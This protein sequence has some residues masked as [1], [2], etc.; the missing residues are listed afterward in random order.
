[1]AAA[2]ATIPG[3]T[4]VV[5]LVAVVPVA[6]VMEAAAQEII[7]DG[8]AVALVEAIMEIITEVAQAMV[9]QIPEVAGA[10]AQAAA[11]IIFQL[12][13]MLPMLHVMAAQTVLFM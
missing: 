4:M 13:A 1:M 6:A 5:A 9:L 2:Q 12:Q 3:T 7:Q 8:A 10:D 11:A